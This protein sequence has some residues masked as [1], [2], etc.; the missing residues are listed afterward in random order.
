MSDYICTL[1]PRNCRAVRTEQEGKGYC[2]AGTLP[3]IARVA[4]HFWE[5]PCIS[6][7]R[8]SGTVFFS[9]CVLS[10]VFCQNHPISTGGKGRTVTVEELTAY[11]KRLEAQGVHNINLVSP[12]PYIESILA[13]FSR[14]RPS[15]PIVYN[16]GGY[17]KAETL[18]RLEG[19]VDIYLPDLKYVSSALSAAYSGA[20]NYFEAALPALHEMVRQTGKPQF[21]EKGMLLRGT[22]VRHLVLPGHTR[23]TMEVLDVLKREFDDR[24]LVS[25]MGQYVPMGRASE[26]PEINRRITKREYCKVL[27]YMEALELEGFA[28]ELTSA[29]KDFIPD[30]DLSALE[31]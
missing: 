10:C 8:G 27:D 20:A 28:Q 11:I 19:V 14:Y 15:I 7:T 3:R 1:C 22:I 17:E 18:R 31:Q 9:G 12:T 21:D 6:G 5:E 30:F 13:C 16:T 26:F 2:R 23:N 4:P 29:K 25:L 24:I